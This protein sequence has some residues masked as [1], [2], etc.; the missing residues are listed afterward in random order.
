MDRDEQL[1][2]DLARRNWIILGLLLAASL[3]WQS[4]AVS[5]GVL[6]GGLIA[7]IGYQW[8]HRSLRRLLEEPNQRSAKKFQIGYLLRLAA[9]A[10]AL[11]LLVSL[12]RVHPVGLAVGLSVV[13]V[14]ILWATIKRTF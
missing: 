14:N 7:I 8:L 2:G 1:L 12:A 6:G 9:L 11:F 10:V 3:P 4:T 5:F 13:V